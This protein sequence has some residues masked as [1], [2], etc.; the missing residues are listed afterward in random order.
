MTV[1]TVILKPGLV[2]GLHAM[3]RAVRN[4]EKVGIGTTFS[5]AFNCGITLATLGV[6]S[7]LLGLPAEKAHGLDTLRYLAADVLRPSPV[8]SGGML[9]IPAGLIFGEASLNA[10]CIREKVL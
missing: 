10:H 1:R 8:I 7:H 4:A 9:E 5:S 2:N 6:F 3:T